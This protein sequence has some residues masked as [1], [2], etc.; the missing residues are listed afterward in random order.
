LGY[1]ARGRCRS[2]ATPHP[3]V[4]AIEQSAAIG[5]CGGEPV[6][7]NERQHDVTGTY[8]LQQCIIEPGAGENGPARPEDRIGAEHRAEHL[9]EKDRGVGAR[10]GGSEIQEYFRHGPPRHAVT[11]TSAATLVDKKIGRGE[12]VIVLQSRISSG[13]HRK[14]TTT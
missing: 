7:P 4:R 1:P 10:I 6:R 14:R 8:A 13:V 11:S 9:I 12:I 5:I 3:V 2:H